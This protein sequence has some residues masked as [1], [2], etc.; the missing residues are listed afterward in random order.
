MKHDTCKLFLF[1]KRIES[2]KQS[3][4]QY[5]FHYME[6]SLEDTNKKKTHGKL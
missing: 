5:R 2:F 1:L 6:N 3:W 4:N